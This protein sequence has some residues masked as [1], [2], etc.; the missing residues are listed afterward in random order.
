[1]RRCLNQQKWMNSLKF[2]YQHHQ[3]P[4]QWAESACLAFS[5]C[6]RK[7]PGILS[8]LAMCTLLFLPF[9]CVKIILS[10]SSP[11]QCS[12]KFP[13][14]AF[15]L[16]RILHR[17]RTRGWHAFLFRRW[18]CLWISPRSTLPRSIGTCLGLSWLLFRN[19]PW[20]RT[21]CCRSM[22]PRHEASRYSSFLYKL[23][24]SSSVILPHK[25]CSSSLLPCKTFHFLL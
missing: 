14:H 16:F 24:F 12:L 15:N 25:L 3:F 18:D 1:M 20:N 21:F 13:A 19:A 8:G 9:Y 4:L 22:C 10:T 2:N 11:S 23:S 5:G 17:I 6:F 7:I